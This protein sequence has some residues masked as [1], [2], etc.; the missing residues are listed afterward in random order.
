M[1]Y[2]RWVALIYW[3]HGRYACFYLTR[4]KHDSTNSSV[5]TV[6]S[7]S[8]TLVDSPL[9]HVDSPPYSPPIVSALLAH[10]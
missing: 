2:Y 5:H 9:P 7:S 3:V 4:R 6:A 1:W 8:R 10:R